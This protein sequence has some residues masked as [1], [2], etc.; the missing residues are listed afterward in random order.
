MSRPLTV[1]IEGR[2]VYRYDTETGANVTV[3]VLALGPV[4]WP[5]AGRREDRGLVLGSGGVGF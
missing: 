2:E 5:V 1:F 4:S 3:A